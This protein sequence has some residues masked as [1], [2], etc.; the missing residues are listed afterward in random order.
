MAYVNSIKKWFEN[1][2]GV[3]AF[4]SGNVMGGTGTDVQPVGIGNVLQG[5]LGT[6]AAGETMYFSGSNTAAKL[7][8]GTDGYVLRAKGA[9][10]P[11]WE[12]RKRFTVFTVGALGASYATG[13]LG[14]TPGIAIMLGWDDLATDY[15]LLG[16]MK[17][18]TGTAVTDNGYIATATG[19]LA[20][21]QSTTCW[22]NSGT[23]WKCTAFSSSGVTVTRTGANAGAGVTMIVFEA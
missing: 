4:T 13:S 23:T 1:L 15:S 10:A 16:W 18:T 6:L 21:G 9:A 20:D 7:A 11:V 19:N 22:S 2:F 3:A 12:A 14:F 17:G 5:A 8:A